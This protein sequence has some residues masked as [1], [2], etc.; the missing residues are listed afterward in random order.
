MGQV[1]DGALVAE[2]R[3]DAQALDHAVRVVQPAGH[4]QPAVAGGNGH[5]DVAADGTVGRGDVTARKRHQH[6]KLT[7]G[8][9]RLRLVGRPHRERAHDVVAESGRAGFAALQPFQQ[10]RQLAGCTGNG[11]AGKTGA[12]KQDHQ[13]FR[14]AQCTVDDEV[15]RQPAPLVRDRSY[16]RGNIQAAHRGAGQDDGGGDLAEAGGN[17][18]VAQDQMPGR[19]AAG[20]QDGR[21]RRKLEDQPAAQTG[22]HRIVLKAEGAAAEIQQQADDPQPRRTVRP[23]SSK[24]ASK[25]AG[26]FA[27]AVA[28]AR[29]CSSWKPMTPV[30]AGQR[31]NASV[32]SPP[33]EVGTVSRV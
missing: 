25:L 19:C 33:Q 12:A 29:F 4:E 11:A 10:R 9:C 7:D 27:G 30:P 26:A 1:R 28:T 3:H 15:E 6:L 20:R 5:V 22:E 23:L 21:R 24:A 13:G 14:A 2:G 31:R 32:R 8:G 17:A 16:R 18:A